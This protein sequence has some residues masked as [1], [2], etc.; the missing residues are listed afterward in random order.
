MVPFWLLALLEFGAWVFLILPRLDFRPFGGKLLAMEL[1]ELLFALST[2]ISEVHTKSV[3][4][5]Q[6]PGDCL[7]LGDPASGLLLDP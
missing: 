4:R 1:F 5:P 3:Q 7:M 2:T 6:C